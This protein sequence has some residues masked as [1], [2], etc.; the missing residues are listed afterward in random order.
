MSIANTNIEPARKNG[1]RE[2]RKDTV[3]FQELDYA[4]NHVETL[5]ENMNDS[6]D[7]L[8]STDFDLATGVNGADVATKNR[9]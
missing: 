9:S 7:S 8:E 4:L 3:L 2:S 1:P 5:L 6:M